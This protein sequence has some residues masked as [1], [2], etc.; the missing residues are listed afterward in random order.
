VRAS[1]PDPLKRMQD[2]LAQIAIFFLKKQKTNNISV[3]FFQPP[4][5]VEKLGP[6]SLDLKNLV[7]QLFSNMKKYLNKPI[8]QDI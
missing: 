5:V 3:N 7:F 8:T 4:K 1:A 2:I 6:K